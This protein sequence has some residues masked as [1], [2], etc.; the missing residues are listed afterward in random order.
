VGPVVSGGRPGRTHHEATAHLIPR[1]PLSIP[2]RTPYSFSR[3]FLIRDY[4]TNASRRLSQQEITQLVRT[5]TTRDIAILIGLS[6]DRYLDRDQVEQLFFPSRRVSQRRIKWLRDHGL[7]Y[8][9][10]MIE[11]PGW[12]RL[13]SLLLLSPRG[14][15]V[16]AACLGQ[17]PRRLVRLS[18]DCRDHC[19]N[20]GH[21]LGANAFFVA[22]AVA[23]RPLGHEGLY[24]WVGEERCRRLLREDAG[25][26]YAP[27]PDGWGRYLLGDREITFFLEWDR[28]TE[29]VDRLHRKSANYMRYFVRRHGANY[30]HV[31]FV[32]PSSAKELAYHRSIAED[33]PRDEVCCVF[34]TTTLEH[35]ELASPRGPIW[36]KVEPRPPRDEATR[37]RSRQSAAW[38]AAG[39]RVS[40]DGLASQ[41]GHGSSVANCIGKSGWWEQRLA[42]GQV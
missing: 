31:L 39:S 33:L 13:H 19:F 12:T 9:W 40:L 34:W 20:V 27:A 10:P 24:H 32:F 35:L 14:A 4:P 38:L 8:R 42:G 23:S 16:L 2:G 18:Q 29:S 41:P 7:I 30:A 36:W 1:S 26:R 28:G 21:D 37:I 25:P 22:L 3:P 17:E 15:R 5:L 11:P 6:N